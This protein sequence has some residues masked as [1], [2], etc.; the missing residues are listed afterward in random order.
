MGEDFTLYVRMRV[1]SHVLDLA[2]ERMDV[3][4]LL[5]SIKLQ[6]KG[7]KSG[8]EDEK[9]KKKKRKPIIISS[10]FY[11]YAAFLYIYIYQE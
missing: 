5:L 4:S 2:R 7:S 3:G 10:L 11:T 8:E 1:R 9:R 6:K